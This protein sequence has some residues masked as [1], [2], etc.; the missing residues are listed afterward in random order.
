MKM[1]S[2]RRPL[3][4]LGLLGLA[5]PGLLRPALAQ[6]AALQFRI[7]RSGSPIG[8]HRVD[9]SRQGDRLTVR[10]AVEIVVTLIGFTVFR[11][12]HRH[13]EVWDGDRLQTVTSRQDRNGRVEEMTARAAAGG[14]LVR[15]PEGEYRL[16][17]D[18]APL[19]WWDQRRPGRPLFDGGNGKPMQVLWA[20]APQLDGGVV[21][22]ASGD[23]EG[24]VG[25]GHDGI[26]R[27][28]RT[29]GDD[30]SSVSYEAI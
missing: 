9:F 25:Y 20:R 3:L 8:T 6:P 11:F 27:S 16:P 24:E 22:T 5:Q 18:A 17:A 7:L 4:G 2:P 13:E 21:F 19:A 14:V 15:G 12:N 1:S 29:R 30:G 26:W 23:A 10:A 28:L